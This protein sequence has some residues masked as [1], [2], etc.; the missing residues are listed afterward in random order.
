MHLPPLHDSPKI[1]Y[2][3]KELSELLSLGRSSLYSLMKSG[4][5][6]ATKCGRRTLFLAGDVSTLI[7]ELRR[8]R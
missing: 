2:S 6:R 1:A 3:V 7:D 4:R 5:L 8:G